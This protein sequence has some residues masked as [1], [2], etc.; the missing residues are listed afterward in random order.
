MKNLLS[1]LVF[2]LFFLNSILIQ[3]QSP[4]SFRYQAVVR[5]ASGTVLQT[6]NVSLKISLLQSSSTGAVVYSEEHAAMT[7]S[8]GLVNLEIGSGANQTGTIASIDWAQGPYFIKIEMDATG[9]N[10]FSEMGTT[11]L[12]SV[13]FALFAA[14]GN[15]GPQGLQGEQG[16]AGQNGQDGQDGQPGIDGI[17]I[18]NSYVFNDSL[19][20]VLSNAQVL[21]AG[22][23][24][25]TQ[26]IQGIQGNQGAQGLTG[27]DG[28]NGISVSN[29][30]INNDSLYITLSDNT[31]IN[32]GYVKGAQGIQGNTGS[33]GPQGEQGLAG[34]GL[35]N[36]GNWMTGTE[37]N[38][39]D[40][41]FDRST[42]DPLVNSMWIC[43]ATSAFTSNTSPYLDLTNWVEFQAPAGP[44]GIQGEQGLQGLQGEQGPA[45]TNGTN[46]I[47]G[48]NGL[49]GK[50]VLNG[51]ANPTTEG[52]DG[53]FYIN[54]ATN[55]IFGPKTTGAWGAGTS[56]IGQQGEQG[57]QGIQGVQGL[58]GEQG[59]AGANGANGI[60]GLDGKTLL[61]GTANPTTEGVDGD[62]YINTATNMI[63]GPKTSGAWGTGTSIVGQQGLQGI[64]GLQG[65]QGDAGTG[66]TNRGTWLNGTAYNLGDYVFDR[67]TNDPLVNSMWISE[68]TNTFTS[69]TQP[70][71]DA[72]NWVE[73][74]A[75]AGPQ[76]IQGE[77]GAQGT[78]GEQGLQGI[79]GP[80]GEQ[81]IQ[82]I[83]GTN[84]LDGISISWQGTLATAPGSPTLNMAYYNSTDKKSY[85]YN[86]ST[87]N[88]ITQDGA[89]GVGDTYLAGTGLSLTGNTFNSVWTTSGFNIYNNNVNFVGIGTTNP[90]SKLHVDGSFRLN[91]DTEGLG[92]V[93]TS[94]ALGNASWQNITIPA[95]SGSLNFIPKFTGLTSIGNSIIF[96]NNDKIGI[97]TIT[98]SGRVEIQ[99]D[100]NGLATEPLFQIKDKYGFP[101]MI[102]YEDSVR[103]FVNDDPAK[104]QNRGAFA[105]SGKNST[106]AFTNDI[107]VI[108]ADST[109]V[110]TANPEAGF[111]VS[112]ITGS[113]SNSYMRLTPRNYF[114]G[115]DAGKSITSGEYNS[116]I[117]YQSGMNVNTG[118]SN[119]FLGYQSGYSNTVGNNNVFIGDN[120][121][122]YNESGS[123]N[124][125]L[126]SDAGKNNLGGFGAQG[127]YN[128]FVGKWAGFTNSTGYENTFIGKESGYYN[129]TGYNNTFLGTECG[130]SNTTGL[131]NIYIGYRSGPNQNA[132]FPV[133]P[134]LGTGSQ[135]ICLGNNSG[136]SITNGANNNFI[137]T[138]A[139]FSNTEGNYNIFMGNNSGYSNITGQYNIFVGN[140]C[141]QNNTTGEYNVFVGYQSGYNNIGGSSWTEGGFNVFVGYQSGFSNTT[142]GKNIAIGH[143]AFYTNTT[144]RDNVS[145]GQSSLYKNTS[146]KD[147]LAVGNNTL[148]ENTIGE[149][150]IALGT[151]SLAYNIS[152][153]GNIGIGVS[154]VGLNT[155]G[156][157]NIGTGGNALLQNVSGN[158]NVA[159]GRDAVYYNTTGHGNAGFGFE[160]LIENVTGNYNTAIGYQSGPA[161]SSS[162]LNNTICIGNGAT[163]TANNSV[164]IGNWSIE[165]LFCMGAY[166]ATTA[167]AANLYVDG[168]GQ[169]MRSTS[170]KRY[171]KDI[172]DLDINT[173]DI[174]KLRPVS[175][176]SINDN[177]KYFGLIAEEVAATIPQLAEFA[178]EKNVIK[179]SN[180]EKLIPDAVK[181]PMLSVLLLKEIQKHEEKIIELYK[182][183]NELKSENSHLKEKNNDIEKL[184]TEMEI[185]KALI[186]TSA[187]K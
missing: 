5:N 125:F 182:L 178:I 115:H 97:G 91:D 1:Q 2:I 49:D 85:I 32:A 66:L 24:R 179:G 141:G 60:N 58:Q 118:N 171:K 26:G 23:V 127:S 95:L 110:Y 187:K 124:V 183:V 123:L 169:I 154:S 155:I 3:A 122:Y 112:G 173:A 92:K 93:L 19:Y 152:G 180:S 72:A 27:A 134:G 136:V 50:T 89:D 138:N 54:T 63:F 109:R 15:P 88:V 52:V 160:A 184:K 177:K 151:Y 176:K 167:E 94:D 68:N 145:I 71:L 11:Q 77:Q 142:G 170:S 105:V 148:Q 29:T 119:T 33:Q 36:R 84:G 44:Q 12:L 74:Q 55:T 28:T 147:N 140:S 99:A 137:G 143:S 107:F 13:P 59:T 73:F 70:Y 21:N 114:I 79:Q 132:L 86:G 121:G 181:Y 113:S 111:G 40:Y 186:N 166:A 98:P 158:N 8:F 144:G 90:L 172:I 96:E 104:A 10:T 38:P 175:Y 17:G 47:N 128:V 100:L 76:G 57:I 159:Y 185:I 56:I 31:T 53:D 102:V 51:T 83:V 37:Y 16:L 45:G 81:G 43:Q 135:N 130:L 41:V 82:G 156:S 103:F 48:T 65:E 87:W 163:V 161:T 25:G 14:S 64:Q 18:T 174:Y 30:Y 101:V 67:S 106:K 108:N 117:G 116:I 120:A 126:G 34:T 6:Q 149:Y 4:Q 162:D 22:H 146:G 80:Q 9:G 150:N 165:S 153:I 46:G 164:K 39:S 157:N 78:Q 131:S 20:L 62:F 61:N 7:N 168:N 139:G 35:N 42:N 69:T 129:T 133:P 75:P